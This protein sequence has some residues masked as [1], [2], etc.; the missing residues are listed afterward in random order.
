MHNSPGTPMG[1]DPLCAS[2]MRRMVL[3]IGLPMVILSEGPEMRAQVDHTVVSVG[4]YMFHN[5]TPA[6]SKRAASSGG[7]VSPPTS[8]LKPGLGAQPASNNRRQVTGVPA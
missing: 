3:A 1:H 8:A 2:R 7:N 6:A 5:S 4:P